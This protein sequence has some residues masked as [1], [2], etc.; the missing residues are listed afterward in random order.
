[1]VPRPGLG[2][3]GGLIEQVGELSGRQTHGGRGCY[4]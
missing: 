4:S 2:V 1:M 3:G